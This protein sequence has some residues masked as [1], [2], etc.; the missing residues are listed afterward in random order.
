MTE[1]FHLIH[2]HEPR[3]TL[4]AVTYFPPD[5]TNSPRSILN[6]PS[7]NLHH[8]IEKSVNSEAHEYE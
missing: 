1:R 2:I 6:T 3:F 8:R 5:G 4:R 7:S